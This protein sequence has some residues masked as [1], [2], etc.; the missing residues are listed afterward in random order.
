MTVPPDEHIIRTDE[1][2]CS[3]APLPRLEQLVADADPL[4]MEVIETGSD[5]IWETDTDHVFTYISPRLKRNAALDLRQLV[6]T[7]RFELFAD[8]VEATPE[9]QAHIADLAARRPFRNLIYRVARPGDPSWLLWV[10]VS[11][12][13]VFSATGSFLGYRGCGRNITD[14][15]EGKH[16][17]E[18]A[19][20]ELREANAHLEARIR[21]RTEALEETNAQLRAGEAE[22][23]AARQE[24]EAANRA[25]RDL[26]ANISP[27]IRTPLNGILGSIQPM[28][29]TDL[30]PRQA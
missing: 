28:R 18:R 11:G 20:Q 6:R 1:Q 24:A 23:I 19:E 5:W 15:I 14:E 2:T 8:Q 27:E 16:A 12:F 30:T 10:K 3:R 29:R 26:L 13:P 22:L 4:L 9:L 7:S 21:A 17:L 25:K